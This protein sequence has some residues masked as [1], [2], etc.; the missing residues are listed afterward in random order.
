MRNV[1]SFKREFPSSINLSWTTRTRVPRIPFY[2]GNLY[3]GLLVLRPQ[4][5]SSSILWCRGPL[6]PLLFPR[7]PDFVLHQDAAAS[8][9]FHCRRILIML[10][11]VSYCLV[12]RGSL[13]LALIFCLNLENQGL[14]LSIRPIAYTAPE[15]GVATGYFVLRCVCRS[16]RDLGRYRYGLEL[17][18]PDRPN[19]GMEFDLSTPTFALSDS[20]ELR[21]PVRCSSTED[22]TGTSQRWHTH[23]STHCGCLLALRRLLLATA[24]ALMWAAP[25]TVVQAQAILTWGVTGGGGTGTW[26]TSAANWFNGSATVPWTQGSSAIFGGTAGAVT[27]GAPITVQNMTFSTNGYTITGNTLNPLTLSG[28]TPTVTLGA[29]ISA[30]VSSIVAGSNGLVVTGAGTLTLSGDSGPPSQPF[31]IPD[32]RPFLTGR[33]L[34][35]LRPR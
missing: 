32:R 13:I 33:R 10:S 34:P 2:S 15:R 14:V 6:Q 25:V 18:H 35:L 11:A 24:T 17:E 21:M 20:A 8:Q 16:E 4:D 19:D 1:A 26:D 3:F 12:F 9:C 22:H 28:S 31:F 5:A 27:V 7:P 23:R 29:G 30:T